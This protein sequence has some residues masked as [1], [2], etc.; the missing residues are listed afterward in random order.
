MT[1]WPQ[2]DQTP[3][4]VAKSMDGFDEIAVVKAFGFDPADLDQE[5]SSDSFRLLRVLIFI[6]RRRKGDKDTAAYAHALGVLRADLPRYF[7]DEPEVDPHE[8]DA[9]ESGKDSPPSA[10]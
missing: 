10:A 1:E 4:E 6:D 8:P 7:A 2:T 5:K 9:S 3:S